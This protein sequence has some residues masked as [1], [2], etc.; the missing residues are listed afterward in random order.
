MN[1]REFEYAMKRGLGRCIPELK[2]NDDIEKFRDIV[3]K[4]CL[5]N[6]SYD[7]QCEGT[8]SEYMYVLQS[9]YED[10]YF[11]DKIIKKF[12]GRI[13]KP[14]LFDHLA[15]LLYFFAQD[16][17]KKAYDA[18]IY[19]YNYIYERLRCN[20]GRD[21]WEQFECLCVW[22]VTLE[23]FARFKKIILD[24]ADY[25]ERQA[26]KQDDF[27]PY[28]LDW[29]WETCKEQCDENEIDQ[30]VKENDRKGF[31]IFLDSLSDFV[32]EGKKREKEKQKIPVPALQE[33]IEEC[34]M[35]GDTR[36]YLNIKNRFQFMHHATEEQVME[37]AKII[38]HSQNK[39]LQGKL[40]YVFRKRVF[41]LDAGYLI[42][43]AEDE[44]TILSEMA[45]EVL[46]NI[47]D[48]RVK[49]YAYRLIREE[50]NT[51][52]ALSMLFCN[53]DK[54]DDSMI[55]KI[56]RQQRVSYRDGVWHG[57][58]S[59][60]LDWL[61]KNPDTPDEAVYFLYEHTL[62]SCC[63]ACLVQLMMDRGLMTEDIR[64]E[65]KYDSNSD[66]CEKVF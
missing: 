57:V 61:E 20:T 11:A 17:S 27:V 38:V 24:L 4:G 66:I 48:V 45:L 25:Y 14:W 50:R 54:A 56:L 55:L 8:R 35:Q 42:E 52:Y 32:C 2:E 21:T 13:S 39:D 18:M 63:R 37:L 5:N 65:C 59:E 3:L 12:C 7:T 22:L 49:E 33:L 40:L 43:Y 34:S 58:F 9:C 62:C 44:N 46:G 6:Y 41:P 29:F 28:S 53:Y 26:K 1:K 51:E 23:G 47:K 19:K 64:R 31:L 36:I 16:G 30:F 15:N 10:E 60:A